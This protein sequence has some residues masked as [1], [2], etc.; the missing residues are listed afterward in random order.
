MVWDQYNRV[1]VGSTNAIWHAFDPM[2]FNVSTEH[3]SFLIW[4]ISIAPKSN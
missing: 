2:Q 1:N 4:S 3:R